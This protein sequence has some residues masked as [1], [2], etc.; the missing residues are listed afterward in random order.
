[1]KKSLRS[2][3]LSED[4]CEQ[5]IT[6]LSHLQKLGLKLEKDLFSD[7]S[8]KNIASE[9]Q[10][11]D[12]MFLYLFLFVSSTFNFMGMVNKH[13]NGSKALSY[14]VAQSTYLKA[15]LETV[16]ACDS[17]AQRNLYPDAFIL[18]RS[19]ISKQNNLS[20][21]ALNPF[22]Y[23][24]WIKNP[25]DLRYRDGLIRAELSKHDVEFT[26][27]FYEEFS[28]LVH[29][30]IGALLNYGYLDGGLFSDIPAL[31]N[32]IYVQLKFTIAP[33]CYFAVH[34]MKNTVYS[35]EK[36]KV[37][38]LESVLKILEPRLAPG[39]LEHLQNLMVEERNWKKVGKNTMQSGPSID[40]KKIGEQIEKFYRKK[41]PKKLT[42]PYDLIWKEIKD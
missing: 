26:D 1:M 24:D 39:R 30:H 17:C 9:D 6:S 19:L 3:G 31:R 15:I 42:S 13:D 38:L 20:L 27:L 18:I 35:V 32:K 29:G 12:E 28:E 25:K 33:L 36:K 2:Y 7:E 40:F 11:R 23:D 34:V 8:S 5:I 37:D 41:Q 21:F 4:Q 22:I 16:L 14:A 10:L